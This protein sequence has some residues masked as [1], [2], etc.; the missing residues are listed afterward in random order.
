MALFHRK[1]A[2]LGYLKFNT[3]PP[4]RLAEHW[5]HSVRASHF[6]S[7]RQRKMIHLIGGRSSHA[8]TVMMPRGPK[9]LSFP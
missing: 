5:A 7:E 8:W 3:D 2:R 6:C 4:V 1:N 9:Q